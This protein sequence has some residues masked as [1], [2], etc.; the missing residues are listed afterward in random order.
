MEEN[1]NNSCLTHIKLKI[2]KFISAR[3]IHDHINTHDRMESKIKFNM[4]Y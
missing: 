4:H 1:N 3:T 2:L